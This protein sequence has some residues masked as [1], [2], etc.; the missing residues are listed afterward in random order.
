MTKTDPDNP[1]GGVPWYNRVALRL[2]L[3]I[4][5]V[6]IITALT[7]ASLILRDEKSTME[8]DLRVR[9]RMLGEII[10]RQMIEPILYEENFSLHSLLKSYLNARDSILLY[11][12]IYDKNGKLFL[13][14]RQASYS[15]TLSALP[16][17]LAAK[18]VF[19]RDIKKRS[20][21]T[22][23]S[24]DFLMP[25]STPKIGVIGYLRLGISVQPLYDTLEIT[26]H[27]VW[28][29]TSVIVFFGILISLWFA[30]VLIL[31]VLLLNNAARRLGE[32]GNLETRIPVS[33]VGEIR[34]L[35]LTFNRMA[36]QLNELISKLKKAQA[37]LVRT[38][39]LYAL[40]EFSAGLAHEIKNPLTSIKMLMQ[41]VDEEEEPLDARD[42]AVIIEELDRID[43]TVS[44]FLQG[45]RPADLSRSRANI[46]QLL[47]DV[48]AITRRKIEKA[49]IRLETELNPQL[50]PLNIDSAS[51]KQVFMNAIL[52]AIQAMPQGGTLTVTTQI[53][54]RE[55]HC[56]ISDTGCG[57]SPEN[58]KYIFDPFFTTKKEGT[59]M[60]LAVAWNIARQHG[61]RL[62]IES[63]L[64]QGTTLTL[65]LP[66][67]QAAHC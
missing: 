67:D 28:I 61:G 60:G 11:G 29:V 31:P 49:G 6:I 15:D 63:R 30:R 34:E 20:W 62:D 14:S 38:E 35:A 39:K 65:V 12:S 9:T 2:S 48:I 23:R 59:G 44:R 58:L 32:E 36:C 10:A 25:I 18:A 3:S 16:R 37:N 4:A 50:A 26:R 40:G 51:I 8:R 21:A 7:V 52:N 24:A 43:L 47:S 41:R 56:L 27:K 53:H 13:T 42:L 1:P 17:P 64:D 46:N 55:A 57:V 66:Y 45:A 5:V 19:L 33:G 22:A 54:G